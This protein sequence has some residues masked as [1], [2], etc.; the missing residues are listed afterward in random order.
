MNPEHDTDGP[1]VDRYWVS[2]TNP[3]TGDEDRLWFESETARTMWVIDF[4]FDFPTLAPS[5]R[6]LRE[7]EEIKR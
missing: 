1:N 2:F 6:R 4:K 5:V 3:Q 7:C